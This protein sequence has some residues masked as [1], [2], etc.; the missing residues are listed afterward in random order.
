MAVPFTI[1]TAWRSARRLKPQITLRTLF[2]VQL[3]A[4]L[5]LGTWVGGCRSYR[6]CVQRQAQTEWESARQMNATAGAFARRCGFCYE[7]IRPDG[8][9][10][11]VNWCV[12]LLP[13]VLLAD[14]DFVVGRLW[15]KGET[16]IV[17]YYGFGTMELVSL[18]SWR[19]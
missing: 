16:M 17:L 11:K 8:P 10:S 4:A 6:A 1:R 9:V 19:V 13:G 3:V 2:Y 5:Y 12:P 18:G 15:A 7:D 14:W